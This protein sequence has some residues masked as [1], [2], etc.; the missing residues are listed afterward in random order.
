[1]V[2]THDIMHK[3]TI[4]CTNACVHVYTCP[5]IHRYWAELRFCG[6][7]AELSVGIHSPALDHTAVQYCTRV[8][9][10]TCVCE[11]NCVYNFTCASSCHTQTVVTFGYLQV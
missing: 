6:P 7:D 11:S 3:H 8:H 9:L 4:Q 10:A 5:E 1:M 2:V